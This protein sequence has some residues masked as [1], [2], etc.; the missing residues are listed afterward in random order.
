M[1]DKMFQMIII[2]L[3]YNYI[4]FVIKV[5]KVSFSAPFDYAEVWLFW[6][7][8]LVHTLY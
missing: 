4:I 6:L 1:R 5:N 8:C 7:L 3:S 2:C